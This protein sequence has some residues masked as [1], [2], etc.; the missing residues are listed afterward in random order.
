MKTPAH[1]TPAY[2]RHGD[3]RYPFLG[4]ASRFFCLQISPRGALLAPAAPPPPIKGP[5]PMQALL[6]RHSFRVFGSS[7][8]AILLCGLGYFK[9]SA[10]DGADDCS[11]KASA[12]PGPAVSAIAKLDLAQSFIRAC[13]SVST[14]RATAGI[15]GGD[16]GARGYRVNMGD[17]VAIGF[18]CLVLELAD[19]AAC[20]SPNALRAPM[21]LQSHYAI[22]AR[23]FTL[24]ATAWHHHDGVCARG[25]GQSP[26]RLP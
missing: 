12:F 17:S 23:H 3:P 19:A 10:V 1:I 26:A 11:P 24:L 8:R 16:A 13:S 25:T 20:R 15:C 7:A 21:P 6:G 22:I 9:D 18:C 4:T 5:N 2:G 14:R